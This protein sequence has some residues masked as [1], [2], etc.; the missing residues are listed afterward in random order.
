MEARLS[1][2]DRKSRRE[3]SESDWVWADE[4]LKHVGV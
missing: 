1:V 3:D 2:Q 4:K